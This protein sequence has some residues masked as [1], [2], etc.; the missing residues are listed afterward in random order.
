ML[1][2]RLAVA[3]LAA[4]GAAALALACSQRSG[5]GQL[6]VN[7]V[8]A[9]PLGVDQIVVNVTK[10]T[11]HSSAD[12]WVTVASYPANAPLAVDLLTL[13]SSPLAVGLVS[14]QAGRVTQ[15][16]LY[17]TQG[18]NWVHVTGDP[19]GAQ[20]TLVVPS[21][22][23]SGIK[24]LG[25]WTVGACA[26]TSVTLDFDGAASVAAHAT[27]TGT[28]WI[29]RPTI[30]AKKSDFTPIACEGGGGS[31]CGVEV[32]CPS[33]QTCESGNCVPDEGGGGG[34]GATC[35]SPV[36]CLS[37]SCV[38]TPNGMRCAQSP[39]NGACRVDADCTNLQCTGDGSCAPCRSNE[40]CASLLTCDLPSGT[41]IGN[42]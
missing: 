21:G 26:R 4:A 37:Q 11:A 10:V 8:D 7:L 23:E 34:A 35:E 5:P 29:L 30:H 27:G 18:G 25:P 2:H 12:G 3:A 24:I 36:D 31:S 1:R 32:P 39:P 9:P 22:Y 14:L 20:T 38:G 40:D 13:Q 15:L 28:E 17:V 41:C 19:A 6:A 33:G 16:R 42:R